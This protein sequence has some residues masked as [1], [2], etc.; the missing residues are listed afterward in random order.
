VAKPTDADDL[1]FM[2]AALTLARRGLGRVWPNPAVGCIVLGADGEVVGRGWTQPG[3][4]PHAETE[5]LRRAGDAARGGT[6]YVSLEPCSH[7]G[8]TGPCT[9]ALIRAGVRRVVAATEDPD[10][11]VAG[12][13]LEKLRAAGI[14]VRVGVAR[15]DAERLNAGFFRRV[16]DGRPFV[17]AKLATTMDGR[18]ATHGGESKWI[19]GELARTWGHALRANHDALVTSSA[20]VRA[21][22]PDLTC[23]LA[24]MEEVSPVRVVMDSR[25]ST[26][27][28]SRIAATAAKRPTWLFTCED[29]PRDRRD[30]FVDC[31]VEVIEVPPDDGGRPEVV[32]TLKALAARGITRVLV[33]GGPHLMATYFRAGVVDR[34]A[35]FRSASV[36]GGDGLSA[37]DA[38][39]V[40]RLDQMRHFVRRRTLA[41]AP[42]MLEIYERAGRPVDAGSEG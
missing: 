28:T 29:P 24:G 14:E 27:L 33:E 36:I 2:T 32:A 35:W 9:D 7:V 19:T 5:A 4:R 38:F 15:I 22:D 3:G 10:P 41:C 42:D 40:D 12:E 30:A 21:D 34:I 37:V 31:G 23:R 39:G 1:R 18:V 11:R 6:A 26:P 13:G 25:L 16:L 20:T 8:E 17:T